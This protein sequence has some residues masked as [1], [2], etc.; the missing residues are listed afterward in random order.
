MQLRKYLL[1]PGNIFWIK[2]SGKQVLLCKKGDLINLNFIQKLETNKE[3]ILLSE[4]INFEIQKDFQTDY[5]NFE[6]EL[7]IREKIAWR[8]RF[9]GKFKDYFLDNEV[10][11]LELDMLAWSLFSNFSPKESEDFLNQDNDI[12]RR[13]LSVASS[14][15]FCAF[16]LGYYSTG[17]LS[18][19]FTKTLK[20]LMSIGEKGTVRPL[21]AKLE[22]INKLETFTKIDL[23][24]IL[25]IENTS[26]LL[27]SGFF[28]R[29]DGTGI[30][31]VNIREMLDLEI[32]LIAINRQMEFF[33][34]E[35]LNLFKAIEK[36]EFRCDS[37]LTGLIRRTLLERDQGIVQIVGLG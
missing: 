37:K 12:F 35:N 15:T 31:H 24:E 4:A 7:V 18:T 34:N 27:H 25:L 22:K 10:G 20:S 29:Y 5:S 28:E 3:K 19:L 17:F 21:K 13:H 11:Q 23:E 1:A 32:V 33:K 2:K 6:L 26:N 36:N 30:S 8:E 16:F 14:Y 9:I